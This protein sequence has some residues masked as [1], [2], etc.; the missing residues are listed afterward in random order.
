MSFLPHTTYAAPRFEAAKRN[1]DRAIQDE[2]KEAKRI[3]AQVGCS[4]NEALRLAGRIRRPYA[5]QIDTI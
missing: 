4:W 3:Q 5:N 1:L 2:I